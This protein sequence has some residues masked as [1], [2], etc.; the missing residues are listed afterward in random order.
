MDK[1]R[2]QKYVAQQR[3]LNKDKVCE[4]CGHDVNAAQLLI[5]EAYSGSNP[6]VLLH[7]LK[8]PVHDRE[9]PKAYQCKGVGFSYVQSSMLGCA[10]W[11]ELQ[12]I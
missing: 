2:Y 10:V 9:T 12:L 1:K 3:E 8:R 7:F 6:D 4:F 5:Q 11:L